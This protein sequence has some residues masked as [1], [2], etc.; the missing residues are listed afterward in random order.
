MQEVCG[1]VLNTQLSWATPLTLDHPSSFRPNKD[2]GASFSNINAFMKRINK[3]LQLY[4][5]IDNYMMK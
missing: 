5:Q 1:K 3:T 4:T 2:G